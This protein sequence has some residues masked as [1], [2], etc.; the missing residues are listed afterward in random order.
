MISKLVEFGQDARRGLLSGV[1]KLADAVQVTLGPKGRNVLIESQWGEPRITKDGVSVA[2]AIDLKDPIENV[3]AQLVKSV[4]SRTND[5]AGDGTT[6][7]TVLARSL[8]TEGI[9]SVAAGMN[10]MDLK[11]GMDS[12]VDA[13]L[14]FLDDNRRDVT[15]SDEIESVATISAN[16]D[17]LLGGM[18]AEAMEKVGKEGVITVE[19]GKR[20]KDELSIVEGLKIPRGY[21]SPY[22]ITDPKTQKC[23]YED[24]L[25][26]ITDSKISQVQD[27][28]PTLEYALKNN[29]SLLIVAEDVEGDAFAA[30]VLNKLRTGLK[31]VAVKAPG[32]G[33]TRRALLE[34][35]ATVTGSTVITKESSMKI[36]DAVKNGCIG[37]CGKVVV[38]KDDTLI[39]DGKGGK[40]SIKERIEL[41]KARLSNSAAHE[42][43]E[44][45]ISKLR[46]RQ[47]RL[48]GGVAI[49]K[50][51]GSSEVE[52]G[53]KKD[54]YDDALC[55][56][57]AAVEEGILPGGGVALLRATKCLDAV[58]DTMD[59]LEQRVGVDIVRDALKVPCKAI[60][61]NAGADGVVVVAKLLESDLIALPEKKGLRAFMKSEKKKEDSIGFSYGFDAA[62]GSFGDL[63]KA[64]V[65]DPAKVVKSA[66]KDAASVVGLM[67]VT[68]AVVVADQ[69]EKEKLPKIP[70]FNGIETMCEYLGEDDSCQPTVDAL[71]SL[72]GDFDASN[73]HILSIVGIE[74]LINISTINISRNSISVADSLNGLPTV[75]SIDISG[76]HLESASV[77]DLPSIDTLDFSNNSLSEFSV[78]N[79]PNLLTL[80]IGTNK[81][82]NI[83]FVSS[84]SKLISLDASNN[85]IRSLSTSI[86]APILD[87][88][89]ESNNIIQVIDDSPSKSVI[90]SL[91]L[92]QNG[93]LQAVNLTSLY[94][95]QHL[96]LQYTSLDVLSL[97]SLPTSLV[98]LFVDHCSIS[99]IS[100]T[101][102]KV[103]PDLT[104]LRLNNNAISSLDPI[105]DQQDKVKNSQATGQ[106]DN[107]TNRM[108]GKV[109]EHPDIPPFE[110]DSDSFALFFPKLNSLDASVNSI[111]DLPDLSDLSMLSSLIFTD[112]QLSVLPF[113]FLSPSLTIASFD[114]N[115]IASFVPNSKGEDPYLSSLFSAF[116]SLSHNQPS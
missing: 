42:L 11:R 91:N 51:G 14:K 92:T 58:K 41:I 34:D 110:D 62:T 76:N 84:M 103:F 96:S 89:I 40:D 46:E 21:L 32:F 16:G 114:N 19:I 101:S 82:L 70:S 73:Q 17:K 23:E 15:S 90:T 28:V 53:E 64:G 69:K 52:V 47:A 98:S 107:I 116:K 27:I 102:F 20:T 37:G 6:T 45:E 97:S 112:N 31:T 3:G 80:D 88:T 7:A 33:E 63:Y 109:E 115:Y 44:Y 99:Y 81:L 77:S 5:V 36:E 29:R 26:L 72:E 24:P 95:L 83:D 94:S 60:A 67:T 38:T 79:T 35:L 25:V 48:S 13:V 2:K 54:R 39:L 57:R 68:E 30:L 49:I 61:D 87:V 59:N 4:A 106:N 22:F 93:S 50:V 55:A 1:E 9:K 18:I 86:I 8:F 10:P 65:V 43:S 113:D 105:C 108:Q 111:T 66:L 74:N 78:E 71:N 85:D 100:F 75:T 104:Q 12:A 56:T